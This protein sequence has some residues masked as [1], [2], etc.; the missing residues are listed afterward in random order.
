MKISTKQII[1]L[2]TLTNEYS[3][4]LRQMP[5]NLTKQYSDNIDK[6]IGQI[7]GQ[8]SD[9]LREVDDE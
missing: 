1:Q 9:E 3:E 5:Y 4:R 8:Q 6:L 2:I 7:T